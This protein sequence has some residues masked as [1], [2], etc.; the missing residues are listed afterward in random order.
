MLTSA[1]A[2]KRIGISRPKLEA[3]IRTGEID[4]IKTGDAPNSHYRISEE[5]VAAYIERRRVV[6]VTAGS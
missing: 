1:E 2:R 5:S 4:A 3:L 6:P